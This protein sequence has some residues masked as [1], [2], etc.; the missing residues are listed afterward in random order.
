MLTKVKEGQGLKNVNS[1]GQVK[2]YGDCGLACPC[3]K[4]TNWFS[5]A[6]AHMIWWKS[7]PF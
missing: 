7:D 2:R 6:D 3:G 5:M 1:P 4:V